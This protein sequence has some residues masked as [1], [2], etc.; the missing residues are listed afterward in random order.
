[1]VGKGV[2]EGEGSAVVGTGVG[3]GVSVVVLAGVGET[4]VPPDVGSAVGPAVG[5]PVIVGLFVI[6]GE[7][8][9]A[10]DSPVGVISGSVVGAIVWHGWLGASGDL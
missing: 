9:I 6:S 1:M 2:G 10:D 8:V 3:E 5:P 7:G 4:V